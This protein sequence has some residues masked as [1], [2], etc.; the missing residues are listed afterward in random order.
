MGGRIA[1]HTAFA[2]P[3]LVQRLVL[4]G[5]SPGIADAAERSARRRADEALAVRIEAIGVEAFAAEWGAQP[6]FAGQEERVAAAAHADR[7][8]NTAAGLAAALRGLGT[9]VME[10]LWDRLPELAVPVV[11][12]VG[13]RD[14]KFRAIASRMVAAVPGSRLVVV[15]G[16][17]HAVQLERPE[18]VAAAIR[19]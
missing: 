1:L 16:A 14:E 5:A 2:I 19:G 3:G 8:R 13:E 4:V 7:L 9:G 6:L 17:G 15:A 12:V 10:P 11:L 18:A